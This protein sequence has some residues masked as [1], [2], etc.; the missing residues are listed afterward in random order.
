MN[1][2][3]NRQINLLSGFILMG[4]PVVLL[5]DDLLPEKASPTQFIVSLCAAWFFIAGIFALA[6][7]AWIYRPRTVIIAGMIGLAGIFG[8]VSIMVFRFVVGTI[9]QTDGAIGNAAQFNSA[10]GKIS[11]FIFMPG[12]LPPL[13]LIF[14]SAIMLKHEKTAKWA[15]AFVCAGALLFPAGRIFLGQPVIL[16]SDALLLL[17]LG[18][19]GWRILSVKSNKQLILE[20]NAA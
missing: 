4:F 10:V 6:R 14:L 2:Q 1:E 20:T 17:S 16:L 5:I 3:L 7:L 18:Y 11:P 15:W 8:S 9:R 12:L 13:V 19:L